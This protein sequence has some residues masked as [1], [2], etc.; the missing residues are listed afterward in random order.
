MD[1]AIN[2]EV[3]LRCILLS[4]FFN[5]LYLNNDINEDNNIKAENAGIQLQSITGHKKLW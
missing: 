2:R 1:I 5:I 4:M 3:K